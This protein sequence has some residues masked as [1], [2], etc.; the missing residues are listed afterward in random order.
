MRGLVDMRLK[1]TVDRPP[2]PLKGIYHI[3]SGD[4]LS[5]RAVNLH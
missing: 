1:L 4:R 5:L 2:L 3:K